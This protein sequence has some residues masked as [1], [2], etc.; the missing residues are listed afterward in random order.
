MSTVTTGLIPL[1]QKYIKL[2]Q[3]QDDLVVVAKDLS[4]QIEII[5]GLLAEQMAAIGQTHTVINGR[6]LTVRTTP[7]IGKRGDVTM[8][9]LV[10]VLENHADLTYLV[11]PG[12]HAGQFQAAM[13]EVLS[14]TGELPADIELL[15]KRWDQTVVAV[16]K[17]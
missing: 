13:K 12:V 11:K 14:D 7:R 5:Q 2:R 9:T 17:A 1:Q 15:V 3:R 6:R 10:G 8:E 4:E 16:A